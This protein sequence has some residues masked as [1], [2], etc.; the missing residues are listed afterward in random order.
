MAH[1]TTLFLVGE[2]MGQE[3][4]ASMLRRRDV[5]GIS[6]HFCGLRGYDCI[7]ET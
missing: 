6:Q 3:I 2:E 1:K 4:F 5:S 7:N